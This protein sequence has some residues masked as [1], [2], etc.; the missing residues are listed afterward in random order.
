MVLLSLGLLATVAILSLA[1]ERDMLLVAFVVAMLL[2][3]VLGHESHGQRGHGHLASKVT[4]ETRALTCSGE[5]TN[6][7]GGSETRLGQIP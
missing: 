1:G 3:H 2:M 4:A 5:A 6:P 7:Q